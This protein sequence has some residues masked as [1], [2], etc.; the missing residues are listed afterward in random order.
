MRKKYYSLERPYSMPGS[1]YRVLMILA[2]TAAHFNKGYCKP[3][4]EY[5]LQVLK[6]RYGYGIERRQLGNITKFLNDAGII[7]KVKRHK[8]A[9]D[10]SLLLRATL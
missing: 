7:E 3:K 6:R 5:I 1:H 2:D 4:Q 9:Q 10:G 8:K